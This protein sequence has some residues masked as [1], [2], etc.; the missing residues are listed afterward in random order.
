[1]VI[2]TKV[3]FRT[4]APLTQ[5][6][7]SRRHITWSVEQSLRRLGTDWIDVYLAHR[8]DPYT[9]LEE[10]LAAFDAVVRSGKVRYLGFSNWSA[11]KVAAALEIQKA[12]GLAPFTH[13]QMHYSLLGRD[14]ERDVV[15]MLQRYGL[16]M[17]V[18]SPL[19]SGFLS[20]KYTRETLSEPGNRYAGFDILPFDKEHGFGVVDRLRA[21]AGRHDA[22]VAQT[23]LAWVLARPSVTSVL[24]GASK[25]AQLDDN[26]GAADVHLTSDDIAELDAATPLPAV[27]PNWYI[28]SLTD[29]PVSQALNAQ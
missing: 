15:P 22:S 4:G 12:N 18:W 26:L 10:T 25:L 6:G 21:I 16:G 8:E 11:W 20:G 1:V 7:L 29:Q 17:T 13:G 5:A 24:I 9:P 27:Y 23:A 2:A 14:V 3:G 28:D 19:A